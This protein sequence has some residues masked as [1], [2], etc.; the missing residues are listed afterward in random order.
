MPP[1]DWFIADHAQEQADRLR[2]QCEEARI[3]AEAAEVE[4]A[5]AILLADWQRSGI[6][7]RWGRSNHGPNPHWW[8]AYSGRERHDAPTLRRLAEMLGLGGEP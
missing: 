7:H 4:L 2:E 5:A 6:L 8:T 3:R 1:L